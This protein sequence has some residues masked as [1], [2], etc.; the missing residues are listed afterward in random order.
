MVFADLLSRPPLHTL[1]SGDRP[2][3][4]VHS[5]CDLCRHEAMELDQDRFEIGPTLVPS[6]KLKFHTC[7]KKDV[8]PARLKWG[9]QASIIASLMGVAKRCVVSFILDASNRLER[10]KMESWKQMTFILLF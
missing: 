9:G 8:T 7:S 6:K 5:G 2:K 4:F 10:R 3:S 1:A